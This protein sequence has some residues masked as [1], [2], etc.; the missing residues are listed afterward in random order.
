LAA[1]LGNDAP[2]LSTSVMS[3]LTAEWQADYDRWQARD[4]SARR[5]AY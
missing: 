5:Y 3:R 4:L 1:L 2:N